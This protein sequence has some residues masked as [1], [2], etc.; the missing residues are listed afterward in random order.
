VVE[1]ACDGPCD[2][3]LHYSGGFELMACHV[4]RWSTL[5]GIGLAAWRRLSR[6]QPRGYGE[7]SRSGIG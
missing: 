7:S 4:L 1:P 2:I 6:R 5:V 3:E